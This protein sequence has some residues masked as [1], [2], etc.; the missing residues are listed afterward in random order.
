[1]MQAP[2][3]DWFTGLYDV[4]LCDSETGEW[5]TSVVLDV[6]LYDAGVDF[7]GGNKLFPDKPLY[8]SSPTEPM[9]RLDKDSAPAGDLAF[10]SPGGAFADQPAD[11]FSIGRFR[12]NLVD[13]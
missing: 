5:K 2:S 7:E 11:G 8:P 1:M 6:P 9:F 3:P 10:Q 12:I 4:E 13:A